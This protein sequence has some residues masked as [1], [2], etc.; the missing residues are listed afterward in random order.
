M[1]SIR[2]PA[3]VLSCLL[4]SFAAVPLASAAPSSDALFGR[5][6]LTLP[7]GRAGWLELEKKNGWYDG[8]LLWGGGSV[9]PVA[10]VVVADGVATFT[11]VRDVPRKDASGKVVRTQQVTET[12]T[13]KVQGDSLTLRQVTPR[14]GSD[15]FNRADFT[16]K[17]QSPLPPRPDLSQVKWGKPIA[18]LNGRDL[19]G[20]S[21][22]ETADENGWSVAN[23]ELRNR[24]APVE[25]GKPRRRF[26]NL[27][28][29]REFEDFNLK[30]EVSVPQGSNSGIYLRGLYEI[31]VA[32]SYGKPLDSH[33]M[34]AVYSRIAPTKSAEKPAGEW[35]SFD[36]T[37][38]DQHITVVLNGT[39]IIDNQPAAGITGGALAG[40]VTR[41][42]PLFLQGDHGAV[43]YRNLVL[44]PRVK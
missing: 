42:G 40:D 25:E 28:T 14:P 24:P 20:W 35:Q 32:D 22:I 10:H 31:Q 41:P 36:I 44:R 27:R 34:G 2:H 33:N 23:G 12:F 37:L 6:T 39:K 18:L 30:V 5:W 15:G 17:R 38:V 9:L 19:S 8:S 29:N 11:R 3:A 13:A 1:K 16:G 43:S 26:A 4:L 21:V 7:N